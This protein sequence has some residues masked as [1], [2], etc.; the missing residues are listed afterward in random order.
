MLCILYVSLVVGN[1]GIAST[2]NLH[3][4]SASHAGKTGQS[5]LVSGVST[6][7]QMNYRVSK[8]VL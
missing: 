1:D 8:N 7:A 5:C 6:L 4:I 3:R 2:E